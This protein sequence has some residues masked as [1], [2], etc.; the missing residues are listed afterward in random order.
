MRRHKIYSSQCSK[1]YRTPGCN[2][3][4]EDVE[5][6]LIML[7]LKYGKR[8]VQNPINNLSILAFENHIALQGLMT[9]TYKVVFH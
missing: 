7:S 2:Q 8:A 4:L 9:T 1:W 5:E 6:N 3:S